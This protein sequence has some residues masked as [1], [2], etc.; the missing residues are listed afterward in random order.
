MQRR[1]LAQYRRNADMANYRFLQLRLMDEMSRMELVERHLA[2]ADLLRNPDVGPL[3]LSADETV[4][5]MINEEDHLQ[6]SGP[7]AR[8]PDRGGRRKG[9]GGGRH[10]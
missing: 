2:S 7:A 6:D 9:I 10:H 4:S 8:Q 5:L 1:S 3:L